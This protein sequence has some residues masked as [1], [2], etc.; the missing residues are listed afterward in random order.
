MMDFG[1]AIAAVKAGHKVQRDL[2][3]QSE[4]GRHIKLSGLDS[5][6]EVREDIVE[7][8]VGLTTYLAGPDDLLA[9]DWNFVRLPDTGNAKAGDPLAQRTYADHGAAKRADI[10]GPTIPQ[11]NIDNDN[12]MFVDTASVG[13]VPIPGA[14]IHGLGPD[15]GGGPNPHYKPDVD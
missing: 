1:G 12:V 9:E 8:T 13:P 11:E 2:W 4:P 10:E 6:V 14:N 5:V 3:S 7:S 15:V